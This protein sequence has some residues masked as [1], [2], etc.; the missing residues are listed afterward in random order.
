MT[1]RLLALVPA[2]ALALVWVAC[3][4]SPSAQADGL[5]AF[6]FPTAVDAGSITDA[7]VDAA[8][9]TL[10]A[11][12]S[13]ADDGSVDADGAVILCPSMPDGS[14]CIAFADFNGDAT[15]LTG[16][17]ALQ[18]GTV[19]PPNLLKSIDSWIGPQTGFHSPPYEGCF[20]SSQVTVA[21]GMAVLGQAPNARATCPSDWDYS[22]QWY[23][24]GPTATSG[25]TTYDLS[26]IQTQS[27][28]F[29]YGTTEM[30]LRFP[31]G[32]LLWPTNLLIGEN[33]MQ[34]SVTAAFMNGG[35]FF[36]DGSAPVGLPGATCKWP[37]WGSGEFDLSEIADVVLDGNIGD[38]AMYTAC[39]AASIGPPVGTLAP[40]GQYC[41]AI[42]HI[43]SRTW[44]S[45][46]DITAEFHTFK[47]QWYPGFVKLF[48]DGVLN[49]APGIIGPGVPNAPQ[50]F[51]MYNEILNG[52]VPTFNSPEY[53]DWLAIYCEPGFGTTCPFST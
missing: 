50:G 15:G 26:A 28:L 7:T 41:G 4:G 30:R 21:G 24:S 52:G 49:P 33:C 29:S 27:L 47:T 38:I 53:L 34:P 45:G 10:D 48:I 14:T 20:T 40:W 19:Y 32:N 36:S 17:A 13:A 9:A 31:T 51:A 5:L 2:L 44:D 11:T 35:F 6:G 23:P 12:D 39:D 37:A 8:D 16:T 22:Q 1:P 25:P 43:V 46:L 18:V 3:L 42:G